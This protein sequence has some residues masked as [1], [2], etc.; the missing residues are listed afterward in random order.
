[1]KTPKIIRYCS[2]GCRLNLESGD[3][4]DD[5]GKIH[6]CASL[7]CPKCG[8]DYRG[9]AFAARI[10]RKNR[11]ARLRRKVDLL[12]SQ[13]FLCSW[14]IERHMGLASKFAEFVK[15]TPVECCQGEK[16]IETRYFTVARRD[17]EG[18]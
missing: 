15:E 9:E 6:K 3:Y 7:F 17:M 10:I 18:S 1:M 8:A 11:E 14:F 16:L 13:L 4:W 5:K 12:S 2:C